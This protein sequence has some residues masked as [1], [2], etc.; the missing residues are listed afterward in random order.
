MAGWEEIKKVRGL[1][2]GEETVTAHDGVA[3]CLEAV[4]CASVTQRRV[5]SVRGALTEEGERW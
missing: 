2:K 1:Y 5:A 3:G 4:N